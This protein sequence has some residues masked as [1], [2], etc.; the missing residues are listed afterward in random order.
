MQNLS[1]GGQEL[2][3]IR[4]WSHLGLKRTPGVKK[5]AKTQFLDPPRSHLGGQNSRK[6]VKNTIQ[7]LIIF[8][9]FFESFFFSRNFVPTWWQLGSQN[10]PKMRPSRFP[11][12]V[13]QANR[14][15]KQNMH[16]AQARARF[17][18]VSG[19]Q[20]GTKIH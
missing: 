5:V 3:K 15:N 20:L 1:W 11:R 6:I 19:S 13:Q 18:M 8:N 14:Q 9:A 4:S 17:S 7:N 12:G 10:L 2:T 16:G